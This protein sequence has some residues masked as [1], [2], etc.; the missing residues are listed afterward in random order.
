MDE[1]LH[2][3]EALF[4]RLHADGVP[5]CVL[6]DSTAAAGEVDIALPAASLPSVPRALAK[7]CRQFDLQLVQLRRHERNAWHAVFAWSDEVG[8]PRFLS[9]DLFSDWRRG[10]RLLMREREL[11]A[12]TPDV[13]FLF[14]L[15]KSVWRQQL[16]ED[17]GALLCALWR[18]EPR[19]AMEQ[20]ARFWR[21]P[22]D[23]RLIA[24]AAKHG[25][26]TEAA[27]NLPRLRDAVRRGA[28]R[29]GAALSR[30]TRAALDH[31]EPADAVIAFI[32]PATSRREYVRQAVAREL[33]PAFPAGVATIAHGPEETH[34][35]V[36]I[37]VV[38]DAG[39]ARSEDDVLVDG[40]LPLAAAVATV[41]RSIVR[42]LECRVERRYPEALVGMN[43]L[44]AK[45][46][47]FACSNLPWLSGALQVL[48]NC[49]LEC[50]LRA[51]ILMP[52]PYG[53]VIER[54]TQLGNRI[55]IMQQAT[56][57]RTDAGAPVIEDNVCIGPGARVLG[58]VRVGRG[59]TIGANA[60][61]T[62]DVPS[63]STVVG[64]DRIATGTER[65]SVVAE[66]RKDH[67]TV[68]GS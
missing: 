12:A 19:G 25:S 65:R 23:M 8:R 66:R 42:W 7:F 33:A 44:A 4:E 36:D 49:A 11:L 9:A 26:W 30:W 68:V 16:G 13:R 21:R 55:T 47:Q 45:A 46:L 39:A 3:A 24:Q 38:F 62:R 59:A 29:L 58:A 40:A 57:G 17:D 15:L 54:G 53:I 6:G 41:Q 22:S 14:L 18:E 31:L 5:H 52:H 48:L 1:R 27:R 32:G 37:R 2:L 51:P 20:I 56:L 50:R 67:M 28:P 60:V 61:V 35:G 43:P 34:G 63:H 64:D 10:G